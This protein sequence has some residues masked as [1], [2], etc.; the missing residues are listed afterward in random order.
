MAVDRT[1]PPPPPNVPTLD[2]LVKQIGPIAKQLHVLSLVIVARDPETGEA[3]L[4]GGPEARDDLRVLV[5]ERFGL[6]DGGET[7]WE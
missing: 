3:Q 7:S 2:L 1:A 6:Y 5:A 4:Y